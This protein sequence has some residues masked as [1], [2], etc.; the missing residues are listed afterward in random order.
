MN[1]VPVVGVCAALALSLSG[2]GEDSNL[3]PVIKRGPNG[4]YYQPAQA[5]DAYKPPRQTV[6]Q[7]TRPPETPPGP[8]AGA[9]TGNS[10]NTPPSDNTGS[11]PSGGG[12]STPAPGNDP[13]ASVPRDRVPYGLKVLGRSDLVTSPYKPEAGPI[14]ILDDSTGK[15]YPRGTEVRCPWTG[16]SFLVP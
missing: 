7:S 12:S 6:D 3:V 16:K 8:P 11:T 13:G 5:G 15:P 1:T 2:C 9:D 4:A 10:G 14:S